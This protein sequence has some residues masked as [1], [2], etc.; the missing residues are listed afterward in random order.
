MFKLNFV[1][2]LGVGLSENVPIDLPLDL[3]WLQA[4]DLIMV[5]LHADVVPVPGDELLDLVLDVEL[6]EVEPLLVLYLWLELE[7]VGAG[8][9]LNLYWAHIFREL[10]R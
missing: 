6:V 8:I 7:N 3:L 1:L 2:V 5:V 9:L 10:N 4:V